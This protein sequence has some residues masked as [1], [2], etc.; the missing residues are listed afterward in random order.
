MLGCGRTRLI[1]NEYASLCA[2]FAA[3][4][5]SEHVATIATLPSLAISRAARSKYRAG[6]GGMGGGKKGRARGAARAAP[7]IPESARIRP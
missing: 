6:G 4:K 5:R 3:R 1:P 7:R 2:L